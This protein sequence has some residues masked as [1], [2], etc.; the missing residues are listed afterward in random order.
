MLVRFDI[1]FDD[2]PHRLQIHICGDRVRKIVEQSLADG[3]LWRHAREHLCEGAKVSES[4]NVAVKVGFLQAIH[5]GHARFV[6][7][8]V[9]WARPGDQSL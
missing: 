5:G 1:G 6:A 9:L 8:R 4:S 2:A 3:R 7:Q